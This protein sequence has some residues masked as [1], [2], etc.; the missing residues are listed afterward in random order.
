MFC[1]PREGFDGKPFPAWPPGGDLR[2]HV[3]VDV[4]RG[5]ALHPCGEARPELPVPSR[6]GARRPG[7][8]ALDCLESVLTT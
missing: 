2:E 6:V 1:V 5:L 3:G 4:G 7:V 8:S